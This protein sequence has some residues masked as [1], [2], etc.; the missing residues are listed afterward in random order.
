MRYRCKLEDN[1]NTPDQQPAITKVR[2]H[3]VG[4]SVWLQAPDDG[5]NN[6]RNML[7]ES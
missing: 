4:P 7:S 3:M 6:A 1:S 5:H 2:C